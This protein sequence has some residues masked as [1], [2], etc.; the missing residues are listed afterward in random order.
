M[1]RGVL[2][3]AFNNEETDYV[4]MAAWSADRIRRKLKL[5]TAVV[6]DIDPGDPRVSGFDRVITTNA[7]SGGTRWFEDYE[8]TVS[9]YNA[10]RTDAY[11]LSPWDETLVLDADYVVCSD[12]LNKLWDYSGDFLCHRYAY[13]A[14]TGDFLTGLN[15]FGQWD[16]PMWWATVMM[17]RRS[18]HVQF[19]FDSMQMVKTNWQHYQNLYGISKPTY[20]NDFA[21]SISLGIVSGQTWKTPEIPW[22]LCSVLPNTELC[23]L[24]ENYF[25]VNY[26]SQETKLMQVGIAGTDFHAMGKRHLEKIIEAA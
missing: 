6:T 22:H 19:I 10:G 16:M 9:W 24:D 13:N 4:K 3:F 21:L 26:T 17:I 23:Q 25:S 5:P 11:T 14:V 1:T 18:N 15:T 20:R 12:Q 8:A 7:T 2:I